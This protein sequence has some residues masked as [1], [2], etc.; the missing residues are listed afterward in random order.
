MATRKSSPKAQTA[1][2]PA[3]ARQWLMTADNLPDNVKRPGK[4]RGRLSDAARSFYT[5]QTGNVILSSK[6]VLPEP[7]VQS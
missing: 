2:T 7:T 6:A 3:Q 1:V 5:E 4:T